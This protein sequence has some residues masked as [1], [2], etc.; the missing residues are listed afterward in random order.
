ML[1]SFLRWIDYVIERREMRL[2]IRRMLGGKREQQLSAGF[3]SWKDLT[4][5]L[6]EQENLRLLEE[7][8]EKIEDLSLN[9]SMREKH[10][11]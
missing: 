5:F 7:N 11:S 6:R 10:M 8:K 4:L 9:L 2:F 1:G 3:N